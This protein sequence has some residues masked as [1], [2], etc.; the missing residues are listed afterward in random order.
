MTCSDGTW[1]LSVRAVTPPRGIHSEGILRDY[2]VEAIAADPEMKS[3]AMFSDEITL[4]EAI[5][6]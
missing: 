6:G 3:I 4:S 1:L 2:L 5:A